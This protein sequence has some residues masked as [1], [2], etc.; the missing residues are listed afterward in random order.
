MPPPPSLRPSRYWLSR[1]AVNASFLSVLMV[2]VPKIA[3]KAPITRKRACSLTC[4]RL[5]ARTATA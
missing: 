2:C 3:V 1:R 5:A 4:S